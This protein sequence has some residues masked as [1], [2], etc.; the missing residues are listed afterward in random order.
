MPHRSF[1][2]PWRRWL[3]QLGLLV[4]VVGVSLSE[5]IGA[6]KNTEALPQDPV[7][8]LIDALNQER[9]PF[10]PDKRGEA[11]ARDY[12]AAS[13]KRAA[14]NLKTPGEIGRALLLNE[15]GFGE[16]E[17]RV[18]DDLAN[19]FVK[20]VGAILDKGSPD[21]QI[22]ACTVVD[23]TMIGLTTL[24]RDPEYVSPYSEAERK[25]EKRRRDTLGKKEW[26]FYLR[27]S[28]LADKLAVLS[29]TG[30]VP[31]RAAAARTLGVFP[32][33]A[34]VVTKALAQ[35]LKPNQPLLVRQ[36]AGDGLLKLGQSLVEKQPS[37]LS[38]P[39][40][41]GMEA[42]SQ[43]KM[44][45]EKRRAVATRLIPV[46]AQALDDE[47]PGVRLSAVLAMQETVNSLAEQLKL[48]P[49][50]RRS[51]LPAPGRRGSRAEI[52]RLDAMRDQLTAFR[53][54]YLPAIEALNKQAAAMGR[55]TRDRNEQVRV[56]A[57]RLIDELGRTRRLFRN[58]EESVPNLEPERTRETKRNS[59]APRVVTLGTVPVE[60][61]LRPVADTRPQVLPAAIPGTYPISA[62]E[63]LR[64]R[65]KEAEKKKADKKET[66]KTT[67]DERGETLLPFFNQ[68]APQLVEGLKDP[69]VRT[70][71]GAITALE[72]AGAAAAPHLEAIIGATCDSDAIVR[73][74]AAR[75]LGKLQRKPE[76]IVPALIKMLQ[77]VD[78]DPRGAAANSLGSLGPGARDAV[79]AL[80]VGVNRGDVE[81]RM[82]AMRA[83]ENI[84]MPAAPVLPEL[85][86]ALFDES[87]R[88]R[89][90]AARV[91][92]RFGPL[93]QAQLPLLRR[94]ERDPDSDVRRAVGEAVLRIAPQ[95]DQSK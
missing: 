45:D 15:W 92:G 14:A 49:I 52:E 32:T 91:L 62:P 26:E 29:G 35:Q 7:D 17:D 57:L 39:R 64:L 12:R 83:L 77:D 93:S 25:D 41:S 2:V 33:H 19:R 8:A 36:G 18:R 75:I 80:A 65:Q 86:R 88:I 59:A 11:L 42:T 30:A 73:W 61:G 60:G 23:N 50:L 1:V 56:A 20:E 89:G 63:A 44:S 85:G 74:V 90:E 81:Y 72:D 51:Y 76:R 78:H 48:A 5:S 70:R 27:I 94:L 87:P 58:I 54:N 21:R 79:P 55:A 66:Q 40:V 84:G 10:L 68:T 43:L 46:A 82:L 71:R 4:L 28:R 13:L 95:G 47:A 69:D 24:A 31:A 67:A 53:R 6:D 3:M 16:T 37:R 9:V 34:D 22:A 38:Q